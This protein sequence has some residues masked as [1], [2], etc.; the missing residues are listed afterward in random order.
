[1]LTR[2]VWYHLQESFSGMAYIKALIGIVLC[3][4]AVS[5]GAVYGLMTE[6]VGICAVAV[7]PGLI[8]GAIITGGF[9]FGILALLWPKE[10]W[11]GALAFCLPLVLLKGFDVASRTPHWPRVAAMAVY[12]ISTFFFAYVGGHLDPSKKREQNETLH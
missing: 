6:G 11:G 10:W 12:A 3:L 9:F 8:A 2:N 7:S 1:V 5:S 4:L